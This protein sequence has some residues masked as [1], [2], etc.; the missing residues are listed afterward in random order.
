MSIHANEQELLLPHWSI[1]KGI[2]TKIVASTG[3]PH[4]ESSRRVIV[5]NFILLQQT[6]KQF[7]P[8]NRVCWQLTSQAASSGCVCTYFV[9]DKT[10]GLVTGDNTRNHT[11]FGVSMRPASRRHN[12]QALLHGSQSYQH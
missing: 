12:H 2:T 1:C 4:R 11:W 6:H 9:R 8:W 7:V 3:V 5:I 10:S